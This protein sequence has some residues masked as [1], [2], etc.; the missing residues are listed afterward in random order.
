[1]WKS[2]MHFA[3]PFEDCPRGEMMNSRQRKHRA[4]SWKR[5]LRLEAFLR[6]VEKFEAYVPKTGVL[7]RCELPARARLSR[8]FLS[9]PRN[10][11]QP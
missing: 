4:L 5:R 6:T 11:S 10:E 9:A 1:M 3:D 8:L 2:D 7:R